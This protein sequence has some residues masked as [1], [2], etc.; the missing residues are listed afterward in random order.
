MTHPTSRPNT[1]VSIN[2]GVV[3]IVS[4]SLPVPISTSKPIAK[5]YSEVF[6]FD[7]EL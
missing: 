1:E 3:G 5:F 6:G 7:T 4:M 2:I